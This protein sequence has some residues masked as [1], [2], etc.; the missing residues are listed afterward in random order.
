MRRSIPSPTSLV[1]A[2]AIALGP[3]VVF[4]DEAPPTAA[5]AP[6]PSPAPRAGPEAPPPAAPTPPT[7]DALAAVRAAAPDGKA[8]A[9][10]ALRAT[11]EAGFL[12]LP[13]ATLAALAPDVLKVADLSAALA[14]GDDAPTPPAFDLAAT[15][16]ST[17]PAAAFGRRG[18]DGARA[19]RIAA[20]VGEALRGAAPAFALVRP[21]DDAGP[22]ALVVLAPAARWA[23]VERALD[24]IATTGGPVVRVEAELA[25]VGTRE[26]LARYELDVP[27]NRSAS[28]WRVI[29]HAYVQ[30]ADVA[31]AARTAGRPVA[32]VVG[33]W[34][35]GL[36]VVAAASGD[37]A[38][39]KVRLAVTAA[40]GNDPVRTFTTSLCEGA[41]AATIE[42]P[43]LRVAHAELTWLVPATGL[44]ASEPVVD[45]MLSVAVRAQRLEAGAP[46]G[47][48]WAWA[49]ADAVQAAT[50]ERVVTL[51]W[52]WEDATGRVL[53]APQ[54][55]AWERQRTT[56]SVA[57]QT[58]Y[59]AGVD[60]EVSGDAF[61]ADPVIGTL[62]HGTTLEATAR[63]VGDGTYVVEGRVLGVAVDEPMRERR[64]DFGVGAP[65]TLQLPV[66][67]EASR[68]FRVRLA[69]GERARVAAP[70]MPGRA[71]APALFVKL[72]A[73]G[74]VEP[75]GP[76]TAPK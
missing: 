68:P 24:S 20:A 25:H 46:V 32:P 44:V 37:P 62:S 42:L 23:S 13:V 72:V 69:V 47:R 40:F 74:P 56:V 11:S 75:S 49:A 27:W 43:E 21:A 15:P 67:R 10:A 2:L 17:A 28:A 1:A 7:E 18:E 55:T 19:R 35:E 71:P 6:T 64:W 22:V 5:P 8:A 36:G 50:P 53:T 45:P 34:A 60:V 57:E 30:D 70:A 26:A 29:R 31:G 52:T 41:P 51:A 73:A 76:A 65:M 3:T 54:V 66:S 48:G 16:P 39:P 38:Q 4:A 33:T 12:A 9:V 63:A 14:E 59:V 58:P 61:L